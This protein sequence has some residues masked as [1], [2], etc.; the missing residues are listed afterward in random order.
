MRQSA[1]RAGLAR[2]ACE[3]PVP[4]GGRV[5]TAAIASDEH[6]A[7]AVAFL[8]QAVAYCRTHGV[9]VRRIMIDNGS[10]Y[11]SHVF[12]DACRWL[13]LKHIRARSYMPRTNGKAERFIQAAL[14]EWAYATS[15]ELYAQHQQALD[16]WLHHYS[17]RRP[18]AAAGSLAPASRLGLNRNNL[19][20]LTVLGATTCGDSDQFIWRH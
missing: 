2:I 20:K 5:T 13:G 11:V 7:T 14:R 4:Q 15:F 1:R 8:H 12:A 3:F 9:I 16:Y 17:W 6:G 10:P 19:L 18:H